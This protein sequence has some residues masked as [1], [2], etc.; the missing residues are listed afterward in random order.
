VICIADV[1]LLLYARPIFSTACRRS[2]SLAVTR[3]PT[4]RP[5]ARSTRRSGT[6][7]HGGW[8]LP[9]AAYLAEVDDEGWMQA[10][11]S[12]KRLP[13]AIGRRSS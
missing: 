1:T 3:S 6:A 8:S 7:F 2:G 13:H 5:G 12:R 11:F 10:K 4:C 9:A